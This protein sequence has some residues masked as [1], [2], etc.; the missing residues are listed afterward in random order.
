MG[1]YMAL[2]SIDRRTFVVGAASAAAA[3]ATPTTRI[4]KVQDMYGLIGKMIAQPGKR[5]ELVQILLHGVA[6]MP[7]CLSYIIANDPADPN[8]IWITEAWTSKDAHE[9]SLSLP[10]VKQAITKG[11]PLI[12]AMS[13]VA[14]TS[15]VGGYGLTS[16]Q[17]AMSETLP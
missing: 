13:A 8:L 2:V 6:G 16:G 17:G 14:Q 3:C 9:A 4:A 7:G 1:S 15:P 5:D 12:A 11:R 10:S